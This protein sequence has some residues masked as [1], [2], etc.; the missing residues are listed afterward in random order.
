M[1]A[2]LKFKL[3]KEKYEFYQAVNGWR[4]AEC[5]RDIWNEFRDLDSHRALENIKI[6]DARQI[7]IDLFAA[8]DIKMDDL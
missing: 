1:R 3:P 4:Y 2:K 6:E 5:L 7:V 8:N